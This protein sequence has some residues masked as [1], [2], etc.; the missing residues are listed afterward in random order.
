[1]DVEVRPEALVN[2][3]L[4]CISRFVVGFIYIVMTSTPFV[5]AEKPVAN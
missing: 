1:M 3:A 5:D 4:D 2:T